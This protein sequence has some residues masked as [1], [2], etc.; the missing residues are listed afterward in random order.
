MRLQTCF[1]QDFRR[2]ARVPA[3]SENL[4]YPGAYYHLCNSPRMIYYEGHTYDV[5]KYSLCLHETPEEGEI[6]DERRE[7]GKYTATDKF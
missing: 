7:P 6:S 3:S 5:E 1:H 4:L 2:D